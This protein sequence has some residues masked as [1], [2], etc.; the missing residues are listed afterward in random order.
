MSILQAYR[1]EISRG[2]MLEGLI[3]ADHAANLAG[4]FSATSGTLG[5]LRVLCGE[6][7]Q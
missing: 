1:S 3:D 6:L 2:R 5:V 4:T 7:V